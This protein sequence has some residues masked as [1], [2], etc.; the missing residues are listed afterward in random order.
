MYEYEKDFQEGGGIFSRVRSRFSDCL[1]DL[2]APCMYSENRDITGK[3]GTAAD[4]TAAV[5]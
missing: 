5:W 4:R 3:R 2:A 1:L